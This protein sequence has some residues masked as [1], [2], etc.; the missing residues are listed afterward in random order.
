MARRRS[1]VLQAAL[2][3]LS[4]FFGKLT[5]LIPLPVARIFAV[6]LG[7]AAYWLIPRI[8]KI[9]FAN[10]D[11]AY[12]DSISAAEKRRILHGAVR[13]LALVAAE[14]SR[15]P[16]LAKRHFEGFVEFQGLENIDP[17]RGFLAVGGHFGNWE[18]MAPA[19]ASRG[20]RLAEIVRPFDQPALDAA[21]DGIRRN[22][23][24]D[25]IPKD[26]AAA[27]V[28]RRL[29]EG[30]IV[31]VLADQSPRQNAVPITFFGQ[32]CWATVAPVMVAVRARCPILPVAM[33]RDANGR[34][35][36]H[37]YPPLE[38]TRRGNLHRDIIENTQRVQDV[39]EQIVREHPEQWLWLHRRWKKRP[40][41]EQEWAAKEARDAEKANPT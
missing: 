23:G 3:G 5:L 36:L 26:E 11:L 6:V 40:R 13:N 29:R 17:S 4:I 14:F 28:L 10:L 9:G 2:A 38:M 30:W 25:T 21:I 32:P 8:R 39:F 41:L 19:M 20:H 27:D 37:I 16:R 7:E 12:G 24:I 18:W 1:S 35:T 31:G 34:Y 15:M 22:A 33:V